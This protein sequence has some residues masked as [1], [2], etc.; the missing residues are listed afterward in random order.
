MGFST[1]PPTLWRL[2]VQKRTFLEPSLP[3]GPLMDKPRTLGLV[4]AHLSYQ[5]VVPL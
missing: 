3:F 1:P 2:I 4:G 5:G